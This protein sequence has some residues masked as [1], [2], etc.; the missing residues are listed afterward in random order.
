MTTHD[1]RPPMIEMRLDGEFL[2]PPRSTWPVRIAG[3]AIVV[4]VLAGVLA[5]AALA[6]WVAIAMV[7]VALAAGLIAWGAIR[8]QLWRL[9]RSGN[10]LGQ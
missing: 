1:R 6:F 8:F 2:A 10:G 7:P 3:A 5:L 9:R 4:A